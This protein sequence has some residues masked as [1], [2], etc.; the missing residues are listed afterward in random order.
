ML[1]MWITLIMLLRLPLSLLCGAVASVA[2]V[3]MFG[4]VVDVAYVDGV[5]CVC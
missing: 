4:S 2:H 1:C 5:G 3:A